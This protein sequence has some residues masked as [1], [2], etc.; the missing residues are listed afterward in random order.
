MILLSM[1]M[2]R[3]NLRLSY[4]GSLKMLR[5]MLLDLL[6]GVRIIVGSLLLMEVVLFLRM[7]RSLCGV[8]VFRLIIYVSFYYRIRWWSLLG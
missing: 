2:M 6:L 8:F 1:V 7:F 4:S 3:W 5:I